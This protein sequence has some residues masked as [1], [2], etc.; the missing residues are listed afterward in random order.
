L[1]AQNAYYYA[2]IKQENPTLKPSEIRERME[3][4]LAQQQDETAR[5]LQ[6]WWKRTIVA[7]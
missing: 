4:D 7:L 6:K 3:K 5:M 1:N 2:Q